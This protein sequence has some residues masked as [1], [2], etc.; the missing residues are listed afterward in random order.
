MIPTSEGISAKSRE[1]STFHRRTFIAAAVFLFS[2]TVAFH[3]GVTK[4]GWRLYR[5]QHIGTALEY[6]KGN[7]DLLRPMIVG[8]NANE[9]PTPQE[10]P[11]WQALAAVLFKSFGTW[12]GWAGVASLLFAAA[13]IWPLYQMA[14]ASAGEQVAWW[15]VLFFSAQPLWFVYSGRGGT[16]GSCLSITIWFL[17]FADRLV[18]TGKWWWALPAALFGALS[19]L[20][21]APFFFCAGLVSF[22]LLLSYARRCMARWVMLAGVGLFAVVMFKLWTNYT[23]ATVAKSLFPFVDLR[24]SGGEGGGTSMKWWYFGDMKYRLSPANWIKGGWRFMNG[25]LGSFCL[26]GLL[27]WAAVKSRNVLGRVWLLAGFLTTLVFTHLVLHHQHYYLMV[28]PAV[29]LLCGVAMERLAGRFELTPR[30]GSLMIFGVVGLLLLA[31]L[32]G[33][34]GLKTSLASD[35]FP[36]K[37]AALIQAHTT[38]QDKLLI[39]G[40][41]WG[42][43]VL[44]LSDR[45]GLSIWNTG[46]LDQTENLSQL[47]ELGYTKLVMISE[48][49]MLHAVQA[50]N[51]GA[52]ERARGS[53]REY[54]TETPKTWR[55]L[56]E[57]ED[58][59]IKQLP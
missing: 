11:L 59:L 36:L 48:S 26:M 16:D 17:F 24:V 4:W 53:Y 49:P 8:F 9:N 18:R 25:T 15:T 43:E 29:A 39:Q 19:A 6:A 10:L 52:A 21:K 57:T 41:G 30:A 14:K 51:P 40:G 2:I 56:L 35:R 42:G 31:T 55:T 5:D 23:D 7:I 38:S 12:Y 1:A 27:V 13:A 34:V 32:Q 50:G 22:F 28:S 3:L 37:M 45:R 33:V 54:L 47:K 58:I 20:T 44:I 46:L